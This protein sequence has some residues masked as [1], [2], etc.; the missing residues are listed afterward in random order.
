MTTAGKPTSSDPSNLSFAPYVEKK[1]EEYMCDSQKEHF[2]R[3][4]LQWKQRLMEEVDA[5]VGHL[6]DEHELYSDPL[7]QAAQE[8]EF[9]LE[10]RARDRERRLIKKI[11]QSI[12]DIKKGDYGYCEDCGA[13]IG[14]RRL[15]AR[16][17]ATKCIDCK[18]YQEI[19]EK[20]VGS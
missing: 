6:K 18:T 5:T 19:R 4:L 11:E 2:Q 10:L 3:I 12:D 7:D 17:T 8:E 20:Q 15:E 1:G 9:R 13:E 14:I 16:P